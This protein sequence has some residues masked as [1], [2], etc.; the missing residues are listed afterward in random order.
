MGLKQYYQTAFTVTRKQAAT[1][2]WGDEGSLQVIATSKCWIQPGSGKPLVKDGKQ[3]GMSTHL[4]FCDPSVDIRQ[5]DTIEAGG[6]TYAVLFVGDSA[7][8]GHHL[9]VDLELKS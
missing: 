1:G 7:G 5:L 2:A 6:K 8:L 4:M 9:E 3:M